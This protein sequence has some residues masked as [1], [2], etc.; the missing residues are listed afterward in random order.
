VSAADWIQEN[1]PEDLTAKREIL[2]LIDQACRPEA[3]IDAAMAFYRSPPP[4][5]SGSVAR[6]AGS[7]GNLIGAL[8]EH[9]G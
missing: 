3:V 9:R 7:V 1:T 8:G 2:A 6:G 5:Q 4:V